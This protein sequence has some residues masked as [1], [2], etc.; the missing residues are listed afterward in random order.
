MQLNNFDCITW[1]TL[2]SPSSCSFTLTVI[3][4]FTNSYE[5]PRY[6][7]PGSTIAIPD[8][9]GTGVHH[10]QEAIITFPRQIIPP[11]LTDTRPQHLVPFTRST[12]G[13][14]WSRWPSSFVDPVSHHSGRFFEFRCNERLHS[15]HIS[16]RR[17]V[18]T[19]RI[20]AL[21]I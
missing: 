16:C 5:H 12:L 18:C 10:L 14:R 6:H 15:P 1:D 13:R 20:L 8:N 9:D 19:V 21:V 11:P 2:N 7:Y 17:R 4:G 3:K